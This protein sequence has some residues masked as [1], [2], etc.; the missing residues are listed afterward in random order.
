MLELTPLVHYVK[1]IGSRLAEILAAPRPWVRAC[2]GWGWVA[3]LLPLYTLPHTT[4]A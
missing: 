3:A 2:G 4:P 1:G